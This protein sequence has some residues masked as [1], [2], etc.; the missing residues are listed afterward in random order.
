MGTHIACR[1][2]GKDIH[3]IGAGSGPDRC[4]FCNCL[5]P[6]KK[7]SMIH[8]KPL[9]GSIL[10]TLASLPPGQLREVGG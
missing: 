9:V 1:E 6:A 10:N 3:V 7:A 8:L 2:C 4:P 5:D